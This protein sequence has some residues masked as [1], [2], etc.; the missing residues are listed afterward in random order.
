MDYEINDYIEVQLDPDDAAN[1]L[2]IGR[3][4]TSFLDK[5]HKME[6]VVEWLWSVHDE[7]VRDLILR[8]YPED[9]HCRLFEEDESFYTESISVEWIVGKVHVERETNIGRCLTVR[10]RLENEWKEING[11]VDN[12]GCVQESRWKDVVHRSAFVMMESRAFNCTENKIVK[13]RKFKDEDPS[14]DDDDGD[15]EDGGS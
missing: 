6:V 4:H 7:A 5:A 13:K 15:D 11:L 12:G 1:C 9:G 3:I 8:R 14:D 2:G 10:R